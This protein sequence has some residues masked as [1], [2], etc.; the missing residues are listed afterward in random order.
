MNKT[1]TVT[2]QLENLVVISV[3]IAVLVI[4]TLSVILSASTIKREFRNHAEIATSHLKE[5]LE[6][7][8]KSWTYD[9]A[10][11]TVTCDGRAVTLDLFLELNKLDENVYH[12]VFYGDTRVLTNIKNDAGG[13][14]VGTKADSQIYAQVSAGKTYVKNGVKIMNGSYT[15]C[16]MPLYNNGEFFGMLFTG[17]N[18]QTVNKTATSFALAIIGGAVVVLVVML[19]VARRL[20]G[21]VSNKLET[22]LNTSYDRLNGFSDRV[23][24]VSDCTSSEVTEISKAMNS[25]ADGAMSQASAT[26]EALASMQDFAASI[27]SVNNEI[28]ESNTFIETIENDVAASEA[29]INELNSSI[30]DNTKLVDNISED[31]ALGVESTR[32]ANSIVKTINSLASQINLLALNASVEA[33]HA[34]AFGKGFAVVASEVK[35][36]A[37][38]S[39]KSADETAAIIA[40]IVDTMNK[41]NQSNEKLVESNKEQ[42]K[43][44]EIVREKMT[45]LRENIKSI[46]AKLNNIREK[47]NALGYIKNDLNQV[48]QKLSSQSEQN[49]A[50][51]EEVSASTTSVDNEV[52]QL[53]KS[54]EEITAISSELKDIIVYFG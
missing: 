50:V 9:E 25:V 10:T 21:E 48:I 17:I 46:D 3:I 32:K 4:G 47:S 6:N 28:N 44:A 30:D 12:T 16:Y 13:W 11:D 38:D 42:L 24:E 7:G 33:S 1:K 29:S 41:T 15:V 37:L 8:Q 53:A 54:I 35:S 26:Q 49:A 34:G 52:E 45:A 20:L 19:I 2:K 40:G 14:A 43:K 22:K 5:S 18:Q 51:V 36:L 31:I 27:D 39:A 23:I